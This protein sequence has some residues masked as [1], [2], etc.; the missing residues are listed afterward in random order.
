[1]KWLMKQIEIKLQKH[2]NTESTNPTY[3]IK[4]NNAYKNI[5]VMYLAIV[6]IC[7]FWSVNMIQMNNIQFRAYV[8]IME[9]LTFE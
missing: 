2:L 9:Y 4:T 5:D 7:L 3:R 8:L 1:M 6:L